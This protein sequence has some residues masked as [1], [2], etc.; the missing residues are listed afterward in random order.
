[1]CS[2][3]RRPDGTSSRSG[4]S[5]Q[6]NH[7]AQSRDSR[8]LITCSVQGCAQGPAAAVPLR[9]GMH[10]LAAPALAQKPGR[11]QPGRLSGRPLQQP[12]SAARGCPQRTPW[13][14]GG[15][16]QYLGTRWG[17]PVS[18]FSARSLRDHQQLVDIQPTFSARRWQLA[19]WQ[20]VEAARVHSWKGPCGL[21]STSLLM[22]CMPWY[23]DSSFCT[24]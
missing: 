6:G 8:V 10:P 23:C 9:S 17:R 16:S 14:Q 22:K 1:M 13:A 5:N 4:N 11:K 12:H 3:R 24:S 15:I 7:T 2:S 18:A 21:R 19:S 20:V